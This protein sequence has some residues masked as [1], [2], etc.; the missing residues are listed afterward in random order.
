MRL[1]LRKFPYLLMCIIGLIICVQCTDN[2]SAKL[3]FPKN[4]W[5]QSDVLSLNFTPENLNQ[6]R[7]IQL[8]LSYVH[9]FQFSEIPL[10][11]YITSPLHQVDKIPITLRLLDDN[12][13][14]LGD[15]VGDYCDLKFIVIN[16]YQ[17][18]DSGKYKI[19]VLN[20][21]AHEYLPNVLSVSVQVK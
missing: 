13:E 19:Q 11:I 20:T 5:Y 18:T 21:F 14:E 6:S 12:K 15:C 17:F 2:K 10:E 16:N 4:R 9:G 1:F 3:D 7:D 8:N